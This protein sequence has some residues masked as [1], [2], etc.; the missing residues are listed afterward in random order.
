M[1]SRYSE[2]CITRFAIRP[3]SGSPDA[4]FEACLEQP[5]HSPFSPGAEKHWVYSPWFCFTPKQQSSRTT[6]VK[7]RGID[8]IS[9]AAALGAASFFAFVFLPSTKHTLSS[10]I[11]SSPSKPYFNAHARINSALNAFIAFDTLVDIITLDIL[12]SQ[13]DRFF[14]S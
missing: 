7:G 13:F 4:F 11:A 9:R 12:N 5:L 3:Q 2:P 1:A 6:P 10:R 14:H 8:G